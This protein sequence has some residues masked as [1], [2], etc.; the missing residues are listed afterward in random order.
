MYRAFVSRVLPTVLSPDTVRQV[1]GH[2]STGDVI[3]LP[4]GLPVEQRV[5]LPKSRAAHF[6]M[7][8]FL[9]DVF[10][11]NARLGLNTLTGPGYSP[12]NGAPDMLYQLVTGALTTYQFPFG[13]T[14]TAASLMLVIL[15]LILLVR[16]TKA[17]VEQEVTEATIFEITQFLTPYT[18]A[19]QCRMCLHIN[20]DVNS[21]RDYVKMVRTTC[22]NTS[23]CVR[24]AAIRVSPIWTPE[25]PVFNQPIPVPAELLPGEAIRLTNVYT[26]CHYCA[27]NDIVTPLFEQHNNPNGPVHYVFGPRVF[28]GL[29]VP[30][31]AF[32][33]RHP[34]VE[35]HEVVPDLVYDKDS[36]SSQLLSDAVVRQ[37]KVTVLPYELPKLSMI[38]WSTLSVD[39]VVPVSLAY[40]NGVNTV[41]LPSTYVAETSKFWAG[42]VGTFKE[43]Q[44][45][46]Q[47]TR[48][49]ST[50][51]DCSK[52]VYADLHMYGPLVSLREH[53]SAMSETRLLV[54]ET[55]SDLRPYSFLAVIVMLIATVLVMLQS[56]FDLLPHSYGLNP[57]VLTTLGFSSIFG[58]FSVDVYEPYSYL[59]SGML[60]S[61]LNMDP[62]VAL[63]CRH[64]NISRVMADELCS[65]DVGEWCVPRTSENIICVEDLENV[66]GQW[67][68]IMAVQFVM[69]LGLLMGAVMRPLVV[70]R[71]SCEEMAKSVLWYCFSGH[72]LACLTYVLFGLIEYFLT[73]QWESVLFHAFTFYSRK[74]PLVG[75]FIH[76]AFNWN[77]MR[78]DM[79]RAFYTT[80][81]HSA[82]RPMRR[83]ATMKLPSIQHIEV[84]RSL[85]A[86]KLLGI[87]SG[88]YRPVAYG[89]NLQNEI[90]A[91]QARILAETTEPDP[92]VLA[93]YSRFMR[94]YRGLMFGRRRRIK[95]VSGEYYIKHTNASSAV[96]KVLTETLQRLRDEGIDENT[97]LTPQQL[98]KYTYRKAFVKVENNLYRTP[99][100]RKHKACRLIQGASP[101]FIML[102]GPWMMAFQMVLKKRWHDDNPFVYTSGKR[103]DKLAAC[104]DYASDNYDEDDMSAFDS[105]IRTELLVEENRVYKWFG[106]PRAVRML[107]NANLKTNGVTS[108]GIRYSRL[109]MRKSGD[110][111]TSC[112]NSLINATVHFHAFC[113]SHPDKAPED[114]IK[115]FKVLVQGDDDVLL[116]NGKRIDWVTLMS[117]YGLAS[118]AQHRRNLEEIEFCS[119]LFYRTAEGCTFGPKP[120]RVMSKLGY[121]IN[122]P[123]NVSRESLV[124]GTALGL[125]GACSHIPPLRAYLDRLIDL[126]DGHEAFRPLPLDWQMTYA[127][128]TPTP[129]PSN[130]LFYRYGWTDEL[131]KMLEL[132]LSH[133][134]LGEDLDDVLC[135]LLY[136][137]DT[138]G[139][140]QFVSRVGG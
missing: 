81:N 30:D 39:D 9:Y 68:A 17:R 11:K 34:V 113:R 28:L 69:C 35:E 137:T 29:A 26:R 65:V 40:G 84:G 13:L 111:N 10:L 21:T 117:G 31:V 33:E 136:D 114:L 71:A 54:T 80:V 46:V 112:G 83:G 109:G 108:K 32:H 101:E 94:K 140:R 95:S 2:H 47:W 74:L 86:Q 96:K 7:R 57:S 63:N 99:L 66:I 97:Q 75:A 85:P 60:P 37:T 106:A 72:P 16:Y 88:G 4:T 103:A 1:S 100:G 128:H 131:Q 89:P 104:I 123:L 76:V 44:A 118:E 20:G 55:Y 53:R 51:I 77:V 92:E 25:N 93:D 91:V 8:G 116:Y 138:S 121:F 15:V 79:I 41:E 6:T 70:L 45:L 132:T 122:P 56:P 43:Y 58:S 130:T 52:E 73:N 14:L 48:N 102:V 36:R 110:P 124:R 5:S 98:Y 12:G 78:F 64:T 62:P 120:G 125:Y 22:C 3:S 90:D 38:P 61:R 27:A 49:W 50:T 87:G 135:Q 129:Y 133:T 115:Q 42:R 24:C 134:K 127:G 23:E 18:N 19:R 82:P 59:Y 126:T 107:L 67:T 105:S 119:N 139:P